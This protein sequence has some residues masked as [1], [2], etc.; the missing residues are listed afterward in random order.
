MEALET[1]KQR[2]SDFL[3]YANMIY[4]YRKDNKESYEDEIK[5]QALLEVIFKTQ[6]WD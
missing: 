2:E 1:D 4:L 5:K 3:N 6:L